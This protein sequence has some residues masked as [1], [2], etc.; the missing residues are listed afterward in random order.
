MKAISPKSGLYSKWRGRHLF[1]RSLFILAGLAS[2]SNCTSQAVA[3]GPVHEITSN[4]DEIAYRL[5]VQNKVTAALQ[6]DDFKTLAALEEDFRTSR[7]RTMSG[8]WNL[9]LFHV[10]VDKFFGEG[11][12]KEKG[13]VP[14]NADAIARWKA[15][16]PNSPAPIIAEAS[17][18]E[19][20]S[21]CYRGNGFS[22]TVAAEDWPKFRQGLQSAFEILESNKK[23]ASINPEYYAIQASLY[24][25][26]NAPEDKFKDL[27]EE[28]TKREP[29]YFRTYFN[30]VWY[31]MPQ[32]GG[33][34]GEVDRFLRYAAKKSEKTE[35]SGIY[36]RTLWNLEACDCDIIKEAAD[37]D[38]LQT[39]MRDVYQRYPNGRNREYFMKLSCKLQQPQAAFEFAQMGFPEKNKDELYSMTMQACS[40]AMAEQQGANK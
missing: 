18:L 22:D 35:G 15:A 33:S 6:A 30:A 40:E 34:W 25:G 23:I 14:V 31:Y 36:A 10:G 1:I 32:W 4:A 24:R 17:M 9:G 26:L 28:A 2:L 13:C 19:A 38:M 20:Q 8:Y 39:S 29:A 11:L 12:T 3:A 37:W 27:M 7:S 16:S 21:W 5:S